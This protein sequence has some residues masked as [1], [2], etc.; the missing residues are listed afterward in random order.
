[1][2][3]TRAGLDFDMMRAGASRIGQAADVFEQGFRQVG[4][5]PPAVAPQPEATELLGRFIEALSG[6]LRVA[7]AGIT[8]HSTALTTTVDSYQQAEEVLAHWDVP[9]G[10]A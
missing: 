9:G 3:G 4:G 10:S 6:A 8:R 7:Q 1:V 2:S 5:I